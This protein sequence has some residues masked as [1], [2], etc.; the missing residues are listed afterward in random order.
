M[1]L[2]DSSQYFFVLFLILSSIL[3][4]YYYL[5]TTKIIFFIEH[6]KWEFLT[7]IRPYFAKMLGLFV[8]L[9][10]FFILNPSLL[11]TLFY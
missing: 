8:S 6:S 2:L 1:A 4:A 3:P 11:F 5:R 7:D 9:S 10:F